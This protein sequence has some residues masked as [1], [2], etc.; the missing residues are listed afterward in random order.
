MKLIFDIETNGLYQDVT[1]IWCI[2]IKT[3][4]EG[5]TEVLWGDSIPLAL[6][7]LRTAD[8]LIGHNIIGYDLPVI[9]KLY[10]DFKTDAKL[11]DT[12]VLSRLLHPDIDMAG[13][14]SSIH[15]GHSLASWGSRLGFPKGDHSDWTK[16]SGEMLSY[17]KQDVEVTAKLLTRLKD[18]MG[19]WDWSKAIGIENKI[20]EVISQQEINGWQFDA[21]QAK[22]LIQRLTTSS[23]DLAFEIL[24]QLP[25]KLVPKATVTKPFKINGELTV[26]ALKYCPPTMNIKGE[27]SAFD[28]EEINLNSEKQIKDIL[29][30]RGW[31]P[32]EWNFKKNKY[33]KPEKDVNGKYVKTSPKL[34]L[35]SFDS[36]QDN[37]GVKIAERTKT[38]HRLR[39]I[40]GLLEKV[41]PDGR[42]EAQANTCGTNTGRM[43]HRVVVNIPKASDDVFLGKE[44]RSLFTTPEDKVLVGCDASG[45]E[46]RMLAHYMDDYLFTTELLTS[47]IHEFNRAAAGLDSRTQAKTFIYALLYG[48]GDEKI[49]KIV[50]GSK[51]SGELL[52]SQFL[53]NIPSLEK[54]L[55]KVRGAAS[56]GYVKGIDGRKLFIRSE[57]SALNVL[58]QAAGSIV[59]KVAVCFL[60]KWLKRARL[61]YKFVGNFHD[62]FEIECSPSDA[63]AI[64]E[65]SRKCIKKAGEYF[66]LNCELAGESK[67]GKTWAE[68]H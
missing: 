25:K 13:N 32:T 52:R 30:Q 41:R 59:M 12:F 34:T 43:T 36:L 14:G 9:K 62:E 56:K 23:E 16:L 38:E 44:M 45:L 63:D 27:F 39:Q 5:I 46:L 19:G 21:E 4:P 58:L 49:G 31:V 35:D 67:I 50:G 15:K 57:Y 64:A 68:V 65:L 61:E 20:Q 29:L 26:Q 37:I 2:A 18:D 22:Q 60:D 42:V 7:R 51:R 10:P 55:G 33:G 1:T 48:A 47:D 28:Y 8:E 40:V 11:T 66:N 6:D 17:C 53:S 24:Q 3:L 54:L